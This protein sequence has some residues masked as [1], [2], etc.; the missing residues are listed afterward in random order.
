MTKDFN[1]YLTEQIDP[2]TGVA[3]VKPT[4]LLY[5]QPFSFNEPLQRSATPDLE[6]YQPYW[7][8]QAVPSDDF[9]NLEDE[10]AK[11]QS[12]SEIWLRSA[13]NMGL[14]AGTTFLDNIVGTVVGLGNLAVG[15]DDN[16][17]SLDDFTMN[18]FTEWM[19]KLQKDYEAPVYRTREEA[20]NVWS[21]VVPFSE[22]SSKF[23]GDM[24]LKN[25]GFTLGSVAAGVLTGGA[26]MS[27]AKGLVGK[28][29]KGLVGQL[30]K[31]GKTIESI[32]EGIAAVKAGQ[33]SASQLTGDLLKSYKSLKN[34]STVAQI[35][36]SVAGSAAEA[37]FEAVNAANQYKEQE[38]QKY[39]EQ[40][41][42]SLPS[43]QQQEEAA[44]AASNPELFE[45]APTG[46]GSFTRV[47]KPEGQG[48][49]EQRI[50]YRY[51]SGK[52][53][54]EESAKGVGNLTWGL[55]MAILSASNFAQFRNAFTGGFK[56]AKTAK[57][58][59]GSI[60][61]GF[62]VVK[63][64]T[65]IG[66]IGKG[67]QTTGKAFRNVLTEGEEEQLQQFAST[68]SQSFY[69][70]QMDPNAGETVD[71]FIN[72]FND[73]AKEAW[74]SASGWQQFF[75]GGITGLA[76]T[77]TLGTTSK[78]KTGVVWAGGAWGDYKQNRDLKKQTDKAVKA[79]N[80]AI[81]TPEFK[82]MYSAAVRHTS[83]EIDKNTALE[84]EDPFGYKNADFNQLVN[85]VDAFQKIGKL[86]DLLDVFKGMKSASEEEIV[87]LFPHLKG[88]TSD[89]IREFVN[90][91]SDKM[92]KTI[93][94]IA[95]L[96]EAVDGRFTSAPQNVK[97]E[98][99][100]YSATI[101]DVEERQKEI[102]N[103]LSDFIGSDDINDK[104]GRKNIKKAIE[105]KTVADPRKDEYSQK[106]NDYS[107]LA[108][109]KEDFVELYKKYSTEE[110]Q[111]TLDKK[112]SK[113]EKKA[114][115]TAEDMLFSVN[116]DKL[117][118][119]K[120]DDKVFKLKV[121]KETKERELHEVDELGE[122]VKDSEPEVF[123]AEEFRM[124]KLMDE[125]D[126]HK[127]DE[128][129]P[130]SE[131]SSEEVEEPEVLSQPEEPV[132]PEEVVEE[133]LTQPEETIEEPKPVRTPKH[134]KGS[135]TSESV[136]TTLAG[137]ELSGP[138]EDLPTYN[139]ALQ[140]GEERAVS[141]DP[142]VQRYYNWVR[143][144]KIAD[145]GYKGR[146]LTGEELFGAQW[147][148]RLR[149][150]SQEVMQRAEEEGVEIT[151][152]EVMR[153]LSETLYV[154]VTKDGQYVTE[155]GTTDVIDSNKLLYTT[156]PT[157]KLENLLGRTKVKASEDPENLKRAQEAYQP[158]YNEI[159]KRK[160][161]LS[162]VVTVTIPGKTTGVQNYGFEERNL[163]IALDDHKVELQVITN[164]SGTVTFTQTNTNDVV[165]A[166]F[167]GK[168]GRPVAL[169]LENHNAYLLTGLPLSDET[170]QLVID[171]FNLYIIQKERLGTGRADTALKNKEGVPI[172]VGILEYLQFLLGNQFITDWKFFTPKGRYGDFLLIKDL[173]GNSQEIKVNTIV[174]DSAG[175]YVTTLS[176][177]KIT[178]NGREFN[179]FEDFI[180]QIMNEWKNPVN[181]NKL[182]HDFDSE[183]QRRV[184]GYKPLLVVKSIDLANA[185]VEIDDQYNRPYGYHDYLLNKENPKI[186]LDINPNKQRAY[187]ETNNPKRSILKFNQ[188]LRFEYDRIDEVKTNEDTTVEEFAGNR[189]ATHL[190]TT[191]ED[192]AERRLWFVKTYP[193]VPLGVIEGLIDG[194]NWGQFKNGAVVVS[195]HAEVGT[196][197]HEAW[198]VVTHLYLTPEQIQK[199]YDEYAEKNNIVKEAWFTEDGRLTQAGVK[200][201][202]AL[203]D[204]FM[205]YK[206]GK[207]SGLLKSRKQQSFFHELWDFIKKFLGF[208]QDE[209][210]DIFRKIDKGYYA[211]KKQVIGIAGKSNRVNKGL[212][213]TEAQAI[214]LNRSL[215]SI[216]MSFIFDPA[217]P[218][219]VSSLFSA[220]PNPEV[221][222]GAYDYAKKYIKSVADKN[223]NVS[224][225]LNEILTEEKFK[226]AREEHAKFLEKTLGLEVTNEESETQNDKMQLTKESGLKKSFKDSI[227]RNMKLLLSSLTS[228]QKNA[229][230]QLAVKPN[231]LSLPEVMDFGL[232]FNVL[233]NKLAGSDSLE[234]MVER[235]QDPKLMESYP[236]VDR[237][238]KRLALVSGSVPTDATMQLQEEFFQAFSRNYYE[239]QMDII[240]K[241][242]DIVS[243]DA[244]ANKIAQRTKDAWSNNIGKIKADFDKFYTKPN[245]EGES[246]YDSK[247]F[248]KAFPVITKENVFEFLSKIG[249][250]YSDDNKNVLKLL[251]EKP[252]DFAYFLK[253]VT[254]IHNQIIKG[255]EGKYPVIF[256]KML[257]TKTFK[258]S[259]NINY[260]A[261]LEVE[262]N[263][264]FIE[265]S[266]FD[267]NGENK[268]NLG[269]NSFQSLIVNSF[270]NVDNRDQLLIKCPFLN[271]D[272][273]A[274][275]RNS[276]LL[277]VDG[278]LFD[279]NG[280]KRFTEIK[281]TFDEGSKEG[282]S[283]ETE[284]FVA[285]KSPDKLRKRLNSFFDDGNYYVLRP[286][287]NE[288]E[289]MINIGFSLIADEAF[290]NGTYDDHFYG[291][292]TDE[293]NRIVEYKFDRPET[294]HRN[295]KLYDGVFI[296]LISEGKGSLAADLRALLETL[297]NTDDK[298]ESQ[299]LIDAFVGNT[300]NKELFGKDIRKFLGTEVN[301]LY[302]N[303]LKNSLIVKNENGSLKA[304][305]ISIADENVLN[306]EES[307]KQHLLKFVTNDKTWVIEQTKL[308][309]GDPIQFKSL[310]DQF[311]RHSSLVSTKRTMNDDQHIKRWMDRNMQREDGRT[312]EASEYA[313]QGTILTATF[314]DQLEGLKDEA[315]KA[316]KDV[317]GPKS[318]AY[319]KLN[320]ADAQGMITLDEFRW[321]MFKSGQWSFGKNS[322]EELYQ[323]E[324]QT[325]KGET[326]PR[327]KDIDGKYY[328]IEKQP[329]LKFKPQKLQYYG[330]LAE[331]GYT[332]IIFKLSVYP[333]TPSLCAQF[334]KLKKLNETLMS[335]KIGIATFE[336]GNKIGY[337][338][339]DG[340]ANSLDS[341]DLMTQNTYSKYWGIQVDSTAK[342][343]L[344]VVSGTQMM[345]QVIANLYDSG[346]PLHKDFETLRNEYIELNKQ[347]IENGKINLRNKLGLKLEGDNYVVE[348]IEKFK[349]TLIDEAEKRGF[350]DNIIDGLSMITSD[351]GIDT[352]VN[353]ESVE[354]VLFS[355]ADHLV[356]SQKRFG[357]FA[358]QASSVLIDESLKFY[359][360]GKESVLGNEQTLAAEIMISTL[361]KEFPNLTVEDI[362][363]LPNGKK[364]LRIVGFRIPTQSTGSID[365][366]DVKKFLPP[367]MNDMAVMYKEIVA[368][369]GGDFDFDKFNMYFSNYYVSPNGPTYIEF[370]NESKLQ[371][372]YEHY[373]K[374]KRKSKDQ[375]LAEA[376]VEGFEDE[377]AMAYDEYKQKAIENRV[378]EI[379]QDILLHSANL[380][381]LIS[382]VD[383]KNLKASA[384]RVT[385]I[386]EGKPDLKGKSV[387]VWYEKHI[388][389]APLH[390][391]LSS[392][393]NDGIA[394]R[395]L[396]GN[397][398]I[399]IGALHATFA[400]LCQHHEVEFVQESINLLH[401]Q[402][403]TG[404][405]IG[406]SK[407]VIDQNISDLFNEWLT[408]FVDAPK[409]PHMSNLGVTMQNVNTALYLTLA[410]VEPTTIGMF[411]NQPI[412]RKYLEAQEVQESMVA[413]ENNFA[414]TKSP[415][416]KRQLLISNVK[417]AF[418]SGVAITKKQ[419]EDYEAKTFTL[420][421]L[422]E[423]ILNKEKNVE[424]VLQQNQLLDDFLAYQQAARKISKAMNAINMD[425]NGAGKN[426]SELLIKLHNAETL[427]KEEHL[428]SEESY[429]KGFSDILGATVEDGNVVPAADKSSFL[430][431]YFEAVHD[432]KRYFEP[433]VRILRD[434][435]MLKGLNKWIE[436]LSGEGVSQERIIRVLDDYKKDLFSYLVTTSKFSVN[437]VEFDIEN[438]R[439]RLFYHSENNIAKTLLRLKKKYP[440]NR[441]LKRLYPIFPGNRKFY[442][443]SK[444]AKGYGL[445][446]YSVKDGIEQDALVDDWRQL[447][448]NGNDGYD[449]IK[450]CIAQTGLKNSPLA[451]WQLIPAEIFNEI[452]SAVLVKDDVTI[453]NG[454]KYRSNYDDQFSLQNHKNKDIV[455][456]KSD[457]KRIY[458]NHTQANEETGIV[459]NIPIP[460]MAETSVRIIEGPKLE[461]TFKN[462]SRRFVAII[463][464]RERRALQKWYSDPVLPEDEDVVIENEESVV[465]NAEIDR[466]ST[467]TVVPLQNEET[468]KSENLG[469][470]VGEFMKTL[471][472]DER[473]QLRSMVNNDEIEFNCK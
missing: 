244:T 384:A 125:F 331:T 135:R 302:E 355:I 317:L 403:D 136:F 185:S 32:E 248:L 286:G 48:A 300:T 208:K 308:F 138:L 414:K 249:I 386:V 392:K 13:K 73:G 306:N 311:K 188:N 238:L 315:L 166:T 245:E 155:D 9:V 332:N 122:I 168:I 126:P 425:T 258:M 364:L 280:N 428:E 412:I 186:V 349:K 74:G 370:G 276:L 239:Y 178:F 390:E 57:N 398:A 51:D 246:F 284:E 243:F 293:L 79:V 25:F 275:L 416:K 217:F 36:G 437:G 175:N 78:G 61:E 338:I 29:G 459:P 50:K 128:V 195:R 118:K 335:K 443:S 422:E 404:V 289:R 288:L 163:R 150:A 441:L 472:K 134:N 452:M 4:H 18:P 232:L 219:R 171:L 137:S 375:R 107:K 455:K 212:G 323:W 413:E 101:N 43:V 35:V 382:P 205:D 271:S 467:E 247:A 193:T 417:L 343:K 456:T 139:E 457:L 376:L 356:I 254:A 334:P 434:K 108:K 10:R 427:V 298:E 262:S 88:K 466:K 369:Q 373:L 82:K 62:N 397:A 144:S 33:I 81:A 367:S 407:N 372:D 436:I 100:H 327:N 226:I 146:V 14:Y 240:N 26:L 231:D 23:W 442:Y 133:T 301:V 377:G 439:E 290:V 430:K 330:P 71:N 378:K 383:S 429:I 400:I 337:K 30:T 105:E 201:E 399:G 328:F 448:E 130:F 350:S 2:I 468:T 423:N 273:A 103:D 60:E 41:M 402:S 52:T 450:A 260:L 424:F 129:N 444:I 259:G 109:R 272:D 45:L 197:Y 447:M 204:E 354:N 183:E 342:E 463:D 411:L 445:N 389:K 117:I 396:S 113:E 156:L 1:S 72:G 295:T 140:W 352:L 391:L 63:P 196:V 274:Y 207:P 94:N 67:L 351:N 294:I 120:S 426:V 20:N 49:L 451:F 236:E 87:T 296:S 173:Q 44:L 91:R 282:T 345:K 453:A 7:G 191:E 152:E 114:V 339:K 31:S 324:I 365:V 55:N 465:D 449:L 218:Q 5:D 415:A 214:Q 200:I 303:M 461:K 110:G 366:V 336:S 3:K 256:D 325:A 83:Y 99:L 340:K 421:E 408:V 42:Q 267:I 388:E 177:D 76:G 21:G 321:M 379:Q 230:G 176:E 184:S 368:K 225:V 266:H 116:D 287:D 164:E 304:Y 46:D 253:Q 440:D 454:N 161:N 309:I 221:L 159:K 347:R 124:N 361:F 22:G 69:S 15:G 77:P 291:Y 322:M 34:Y 471:S 149:K 65:R 151:L 242:T 203:A 86:D 318:D 121:N 153:L 263:P 179:G 410:G 143:N 75:V 64:T 278:V 438:E 66:K 102:V 419:R 211:N 181:S 70:R 28:L 158:I 119:R 145:E 38:F 154:A 68:D 299:S 431:P 418:Q 319:K 374:N 39:D 192:I 93:N 80:D 180:T 12:A 432:F 269:Y 255:K 281:L 47:L 228:L 206:L 257:D 194:N 112:L 385:W 27:G 17:T 227:P 252:G 341:S 59:T 216:V 363:K 172:G 142:D 187:Q 157:P 167:A 446:F 460:K 132:I 106:L 409:E 265:N 6:S 270:N 285:L 458:H 131:V 401:N 371:K 433:F 222:K 90:E 279:K 387:E 359:K 394:D 292:L 250:T 37:R 316:I 381:N 123:S 314:E 85:S 305:G 470:S 98:L 54:I 251:N 357:N 393:F 223:P 326:K 348:D 141:T 220:E 209:I 92:V 469:M 310:E 174:K 360:A 261:N 241:G 297:K 215:T 115:Q 16:K 320:K 89:D 160:Q 40:W 148:D 56:T 24:V 96:K 210:A 53:K 420:D 353:R 380:K 307:F 8:D 189:R 58:V 182:N 162:D 405:N 95:K 234:M 358:V 346:N 464:Y 202:E 84:N 224:V 264:D 435:E 147:N 235:L 333:L 104:E 229:D 462:V 237:L 406:A 268:Y 283:N 233:G 169:D 213:L 127:I 170:K 312:H 97:D 198:H 473:E 11:R 344:R 199:L 329:K 19:V 111:Q 395:F 313:H 165:Q 362:E 190:V 277:K